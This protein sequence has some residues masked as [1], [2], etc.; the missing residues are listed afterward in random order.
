[1]TVI[2]PSTRIEDVYNQIRELDKRIDQVNSKLASIL[3]LSGGLN[4]DIFVQAGHPFTML[5]HEC[6]SVRFGTQTIA[7]GTVYATPTAASTSNAA[8]YGFGM[9]IDTTNAT[10]SILGQPGE[11]II[12]FTLWWQWAA[13]SSGTRAMQW[14]EVN[15]GNAVQDLIFSNSASLVTYNHITHVRRVALVDT[16]YDLQV[17][18]NSGGNLNGDGLLTAYRIR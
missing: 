5:P 4:P 2:L 11:S 13:N 6:A 17:Y 12:G 16:T 3:D 9:N 18:Q 8:S 15:A 1:M 14:R 10:I 7:T